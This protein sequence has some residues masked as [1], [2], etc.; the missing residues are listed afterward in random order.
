MKLVT[1]NILHGRTPG[2][3]VDLDRFV[4]CVAGLDADIL[5]LQEVDSIQ[6]RSGL[7]DLTALAAEAMGARS[8]RFVAAIAGT[9]GATWMAATGEEQPG[10]AAYGVA[11]LSRYPAVSWQVA[12]L[13]RIPFPFPLY[14][15]E[16]RK[17]VVVHEEPRAAVIGRFDTPLGELTVA[18]T[19]LS[20]VPGWNRYQLHHLMRDVR[21]LPSPWIVT[22]DLN[23][24][25][26]PARRWSR[27]HCLASA[28]TFPADRPTRQLDHVLTDEPAF[29]IRSYDTP[30]MA[31]SDHRPL[32]VDL[33]RIGHEND[34]AAR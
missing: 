34:S 25:A 8:H 32:V 27:L 18:N 26:K 3:E 9:P 24:P 29:T 20:F 33:E 30:E 10:T 28:P 23:M 21:G 11:L 2:A 12:R 6:A 14:L 17:V 13:P 5:A 16:P 31:I 4:D 15:R 19:H 22:G 7:A 1:F